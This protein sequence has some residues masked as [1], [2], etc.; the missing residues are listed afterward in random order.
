MA[1]PAPERM[2]HLP[3]DPI[4][5]FVV[6]WFVTWIDGKP[7]FRLTGPEKRIT[8]VNQ[9]RCWVCG[10]KL[11]RERSFVIGPMC[12]VNRV[13][14][15]PPSHHE[16]ATYSAQNCP[17]LTKPHMVRREDDL[18]RSCKENVAG[19]MIASNP[20]VIAVWNC[21][22]YKVIPAPAKDDRDAWLI[23]VGEP[24]SVEWYKEGRTA[25]HDEVSQVMVDR[26]PILS[27]MAREEGQEALLALGRAIDKARTYYPKQEAVAS[28]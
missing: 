19:V 24:Y 8:A 13:S 10:G 26:L 11:T 2:R 17:F 18:T 4:R 3:V 20:G 16:C 23:Q 1:T 9:N 15:E 25:T 12:T 21:L 27:E 6:P 22:D 5:G 14:A 28:G 7:E